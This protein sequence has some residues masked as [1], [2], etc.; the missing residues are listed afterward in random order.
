[1]IFFSIAAGFI[2]YESSSTSAN[3]GFGSE[4]CDYAR[5]SENV[6]WRSYHLIAF[7]YRAPLRQPITHRFRSICQLRITAE[8][9]AIFSRTRLPPAQG[10]P[11]DCPPRSL[12][13]ASPLLYTLRIAPLNPKWNLHHICVSLF[14]L[15]QKSMIR[16]HSPSW[17]LCPCPFH[18]FNMP[19]Y[20]IGV[21]VRENPW[22]KSTIH[23]LQS[24]MP[25]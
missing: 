21:Q 13:P 6:K 9:S 25:L 17:R 19:Q 18:I 1:V 3:T 23:N 2:L 22:I 10:R 11:F 16:L 24:T 7:L 20:A 5:R 4:P 15:R 14:P 12:S 8:V